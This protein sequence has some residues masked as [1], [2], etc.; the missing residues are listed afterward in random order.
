[1]GMKEKQWRVDPE[2][3]YRQLT[4]QVKGMTASQISL[5]LFLAVREMEDGPATLA[6]IQKE[7]GISRASIERA[8]PKLKQ[9]NIIVEAN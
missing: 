5:A 4:A 3:S 2:L 6:E 8:M 7:L 1:M 9:R